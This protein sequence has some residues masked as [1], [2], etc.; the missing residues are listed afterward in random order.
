MDMK[1][2]KC[3]AMSTKDAKEIRYDKRMSCWK[4]KVEQKE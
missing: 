2:R 4:D 3:K 1:R